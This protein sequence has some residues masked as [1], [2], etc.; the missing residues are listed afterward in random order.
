M[1][2]GRHK[3]WYESPREYPSGPVVRVSDELTDDEIIARRGCL[4]EALGPP[5]FWA[6]GQ[7]GKASKVGVAC[8]PPFLPSIRMSLPLFRP[9]LACLPLLL[10]GM[11]TPCLGFPSL[12]HKLKFPA[13][14]AFEAATQASAI[15]RNSAGDGLVLYDV[16][17]VEDDGPGIGSDAAFLD[18]GQRAPTVVVAGDV[19][20]KKILWVTPPEASAARLYVPE[21]L[22]VELNGVLIPGPA[23]KK[24]REVPVSLLKQGDNQVVLSASAQT[25]QSVKIAPR[26]DILRNAPERKELPHR[27]STSA[28]SGGHWSDVDGEA[29]VRLQLFQFAGAGSLVSPV[30]DVAQDE[31][32]KTG[33][34]GP[35][36]IESILLRHESDL[37]AG[38]SIELTSRTGT[39]PVY[40]AASWG[41][42][43]AASGVASTNQ[44]YLQWK[45]VLK[46][47]H[48]TTTPTLRN[49]TVEVTVAAGAPPV[50]ATR[51]QVIGAQNAEIH[52][53]SIPFEYEN[54]SHPRLVALRRKYKLDEVV[55][56]AATE[57]EK[58][59]K[60]RDWVSR[61]WKY[62][63]PVSGGYPAWD[64]DEILTRRTGFCVQYAIV[65]MQ[66]ALSLGYQTR[67]VFGDHPGT[68]QAGHEVCEVWSNEYR[69][70]IY[71][72]PNNNEHYVDPA[73]GIPLSMLET[74]DRLLQT[75]YPG[76]IAAYTNRPTAPAHSKYIGIRRGLSQTPVVGEVP[77]KEWDSWTKW[78]HVRYMPRNNFYAQPRPGPV[79]QGLHWDWPDYF[80]VEDAQSPRNGCYRNFT[81]R[82]SDVDSTLNQV[83]FAVE[84]G[85]KEGD[86]E[87]QMGT[88]TP[89]FEVFEVRRDGGSWGAASAKYVWI[90][91][92][93][94]NQLEMRSRNTSGV[95]GPISSLQLVFAS[96]TQ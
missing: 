88:V 75:F 7:Q 69:K 82:R 32:G 41:F 24:Y 31:P 15:Q 49:V 14:D 11:G 63:P 61:Q 16:T 65:Y 60:L 44:R 87:I 92:P 35:V 46:T 73:T 78:L 39:T 55:A 10:F 57:L 22:T 13:V 8:P 85:Q 76:R 70:W 89:W 4:A 17:L 48:S 12:V 27:T 43:Q 36:S 74:H 30:I 96:P 20:L 80:I 64:A 5:I 84:Y 33:I 86:L 38:T 51:V 93:G 37:P 77:P 54:P 9:G 6:G 59:I 45:A 90:L 21:G 34:S 95:T 68:I 25:R 19:R 28:D 67:F 2:G 26:A 58:F 66:C 18:E 71:M 94:A 52:H 47:L 62:N 40:E 72:D 56:G 83:R 81:A 29:M 91:K 50:W 53:T 3:R 79:S 23:D 42:W 1:A